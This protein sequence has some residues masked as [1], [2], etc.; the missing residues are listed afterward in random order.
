[1]EGTSEKLKELSILYKIGKASA[2][3]FDFPGF[4]AS[5][6]DV[7][8]KDFDASGFSLLLME[9]G[10][11]VEKASSGLDRQVVEE[12][13]RAFDEICRSGVFESFDLVSM[14]TLKGR[15][16]AF[17]SGA[18]DCGSSLYCLSLDHYSG[19]FGI[20]L[21]AKE[22]RSEEDFN[23]H[24]EL[25]KAMKA[26]LSEGLANVKL[27]RDQ[28]RLTEFTESILRNM[29]SG[30]IAIGLDGKVMYFNTSA[31]ELLG[32]ETRDIVGKEVEE[33]F[34]A[35]SG[36]SVL[37]GVLKGGAAEEE[38]YLK[39][40]SGA[41][42]PVSMRVSCIRDEKSGITGAVG[43]FNDL[44]ESRRIEDQLRRTEKLASL[45]ELSAGVA[46]EIRNPLAGIATSA[47]VL[48]SKFEEDDKRTKFI[49]IILEEVERLDKIVER[50]L[51]FAK[52]VAPSLSFTDLRE[53]IERV[54]ALSGDLIRSNG[55][56]VVKQYEE[57]IP[58]VYIDQDQM[59][60]VIHNLVTNALHSMPQGGTLT[61][62]L[63]SLKK[64]GP[65]RRRKGDLESIRLQP[66]EFLRLEIIDTGCGIP[67]EIVD[68]LFDPFFTTRP[69]GTGLGLSI[70]QSIIRE[71]GGTIA[72]SSEEGRGTVA[73]VEL[74]L[75]KRKAR[76]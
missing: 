16:P 76:S 66:K 29:N 50:V 72:V 68:R 53:S 61:F 38:V 20:L 40:S 32:Y 59:V 67:K 8:T 9:D 13:L 36:G 43:I 46:H 49:D 19:L 1:M 69:E 37:K 71:H 57:P 39:N 35:G 42:I 41:E 64:A 26:I 14:D 54:L 12:A 10:K 58:M 22:F 4:L 21:I 7:L 34:G 60:Q 70:S 30:L 3:A 62:R 25:F 63:L 6:G 55:I 11:L 2:S 65:H 17:F 28:V 18:C 73:T 33:V 15:F 52:P 45:G 23:V 74:P 5:I 47:Q 31:Q 48:K 75:E 24:I 27:M 51:L 56:S 44:S